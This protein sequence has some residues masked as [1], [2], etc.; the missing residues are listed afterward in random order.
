MLLT[1]HGAIE[2]VNSSRV[3]WTPFTVLVEPIQSYFSVPSYANRTQTMAMKVTV[4]MGCVVRIVRS[5]ASFV[6]RP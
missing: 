5:I 1:C 2:F 4:D 6:T 3:E